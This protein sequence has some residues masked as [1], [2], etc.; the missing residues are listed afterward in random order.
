MNRLRAIF[1][2]PFKGEAG[3]RMGAGQGPIPTLSRPI[4]NVVRTTFPLKGRETGR[5]ALWGLSRIF[6]LH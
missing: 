4:A 6:A 1:S 2:S 3:R 5:M